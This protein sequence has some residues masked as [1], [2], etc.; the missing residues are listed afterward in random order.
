MTYGEVR[1]LFRRRDGGGV[2]KQQTRPCKSTASY[3]DTSALPPALKAALIE[4][5]KDPSK[6][7]EILE[8]LRPC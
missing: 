5:T 1:S 8:A 4:S 7:L 3:L 6:L 2:L